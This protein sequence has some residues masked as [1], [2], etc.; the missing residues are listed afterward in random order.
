MHVSKALPQSFSFAQDGCTCALCAGFTDRVR[1][2]GGLPRGSG[3]LSPKTRSKDSSGD[4]GVWGCVCDHLIG[5][6]AFGVIYV[7]PH[8]VEPV[9]HRRDERWS[10]RTSNR[11]ARSFELSPCGHQRWRWRWEHRGGRSAR[12]HPGGSN[13]GDFSRGSWWPLR[14]LTK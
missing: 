5:H 9:E 3:G 2:T 8:L 7:P 12:P 13:L 10:W 4:W 11:R 1:P 6:S 14:R